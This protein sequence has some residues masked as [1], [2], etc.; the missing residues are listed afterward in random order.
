MERN[1]P[2]KSVTTKG[3]KKRAPKNLNYRGILK[4]SAV[5]WMSIGLI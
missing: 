4:I 3:T 2:D 5:L 1:H